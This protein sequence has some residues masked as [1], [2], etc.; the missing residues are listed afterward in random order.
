MITKIVTDIFG[1]HPPIA[2]V[3]FF[4]V[5]GAADS[6]VHWPGLPGGVYGV[7]EGQWNRRSRFDERD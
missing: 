1:R 5:S 2:I 7:S 3:F 4:A 6:A